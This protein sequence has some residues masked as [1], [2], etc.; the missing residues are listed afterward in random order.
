[1]QNILK[2]GVVLGVFIMTPFAVAFITLPLE[3][4]GAD[5]PPEFVAFGEW[6]I[7]AIGAYPT[8]LITTA[9]VAV[10]AF[11]TV[12][13]TELNNILHETTC[14]ECGKN[15]CLSYDYVLYNSGTQ[16][17]HEDEV[18]DDNGEL[19]GTITSGYSYK[20]SL[21]ATCTTRNERVEI[22]DWNWYV[23]T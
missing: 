18:Y 13:H 3:Q 20:G 2:A 19:K 11:S 10:A 21:Y 17:E 12:G 22:E 15:F 9:G 8:M 6:V 5:I 4:I 16:K 1:M 14:D 23:S 7:S